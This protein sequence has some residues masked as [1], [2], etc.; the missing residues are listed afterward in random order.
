[1]NVV[2]NGSRPRLT[3]SIQ[4][5]LKSVFPS[6]ELWQPYGQGARQTF[7]LIAAKTPTP[8]KTLYSRLDPESSWQRIPEDE[9][10]K[11]Q[12]LT[13]PLLLTDDFA[14]VDRLIG[15]E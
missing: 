2:D 15:V 9:T 14:P 10:A 11:L 12:Q 8:K 3:L 13:E 6:V 1:M 5:T 4:R 7:V